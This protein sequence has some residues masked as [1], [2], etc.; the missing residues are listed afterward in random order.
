M[1]NEDKD[2][3]LLRQR[4]RAL[5]E[6]EPVPPFQHLWHGANA[7]QEGR[8]RNGIQWLLPAT[9]VLIIAGMLWTLQRDGKPVDDRRRIETVT[10]ITTWQ[11]YTDFLLS[12]QS[13]GW[14]APT[15]FILETIDT[16]SFETVPDMNY[17]IFEQELS[18]L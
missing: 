8:N 15:D 3:V 6:G 4:F 12:D 2:D 14:S 18:P 11:S 10:S 5:H 7:I 17:S 9:L 1:T 16:A 13:L